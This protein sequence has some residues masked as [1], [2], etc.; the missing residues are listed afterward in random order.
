MLIIKYLF[1]NKQN[2]RYFYTIKIIIDSNINYKLKSFIRKR[3]KTIIIN[4]YFKRN[5]RNQSSINYLQID[6]IYFLIN[7]YIN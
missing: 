7:Y 5:S 6:Q 3:K 1:I 2:Y 4:L